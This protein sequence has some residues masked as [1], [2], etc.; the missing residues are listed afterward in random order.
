MSLFGKYRERI[1]HQHGWEV[2]LRCPRCHHEDLPQYV[3]WTPSRSINTGDTPT[4]Y[5]NLLCPQC[6][7][8]LKKPAAD[9][10]RELFRDVSIPP[11]NKSLLSIFLFVM[12]GLPIMM[13]GILF[14]GVRAGW[15]DNGAFVW[16]GLLWIVFA[17][18]IVLFNYSVHSI[19]F[20][21][22]C[23]DPRYLFMGMLGRSYC[24]RCSCGKLL[25]LRD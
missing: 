2:E 12:I 9:K 15:W 21:C 7:Q 5:A 6:G 3:G 24:Y 23:G 20:S 8:D 18:A 16:F 25:R 4:I 13:A 1:Q 10:L 22:E 11:R 17:P 19:R 14:A